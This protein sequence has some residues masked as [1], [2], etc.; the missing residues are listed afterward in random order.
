VTYLRHGAHAPWQSIAGTRVVCRFRALRRRLDGATI[1][2]HAQRFDGLAYVMPGCLPRHGPVT[3]LHHATHHPRLARAAVSTARRR[4][5]TGATLVGRHELTVLEGEI[6]AADLIRVESGLVRGQLL[7]AGV[8]EERLVMARPGVDLVRFRPGSRSA[9]SV[10][11]YVGALALW[12]GVDVLAELSRS[13]DGRGVRLEVI[14]GPVCRWS[15]RI[16]EPLQRADTTSV[17]DLLG[18]A[19]ALVLPS[20]ADGF[21]YVVLEAMASG[22]VPF[23]TPAVGAAELVREL[24]PRLVIDRCDFAEAVPELLAT[25]PMAR[26]AAQARVIAECHDR[27]AMAAY[28][29]RELL[30]AARRRGLIA[31]A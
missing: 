21:G 17:P 29:A 18:R 3:I 11:A 26:L 8:A 10:V 5:G 14:G 4:T 30:A 24:D 2:R 22:A 15:R 9:A 12:K 16:A 1:A 19:V 27:M 23:V 25:L 13:L 28:A 7:D 31:S 20:V 6:A